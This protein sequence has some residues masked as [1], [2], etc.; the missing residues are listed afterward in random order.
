MARREREFVRFRSCVDPD[1]D[2]ETETSRIVDAFER[3]KL[4]VNQNVTTKSWLKQKS[5]VTILSFKMVSLLKT[6]INPLL[7]VII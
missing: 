7:S 5:L 3:L 2:F 6:W 4:G 1:M